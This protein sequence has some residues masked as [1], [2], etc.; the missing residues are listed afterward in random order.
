MKAIFS[1]IGIIIGAWIGE[2]ENDPLTGAAFGFFIGLLSGTLV[3]FNRR[4]FVLEEQLKLVRDNLIGSSTTIKKEQADV[5]SRPVVDT[6]AITEIPETEEVTTEISET[7]TE[8]V[9]STAT[10]TS[11]DS[12]PAATLPPLSDNPVFRFIKRFFTSGNVVVKVAVILLFFGVS[13]LVK[14]AAERN[15]LPIEFRLAAIAAGAIVMLIFGWRLR[16]K[17]ANYALVLQ[18]GAV[19]VLYLTVFA[20]AKL[21][22]V[23]PF[24][25]AFF[26]MLGLVVFS[27][28]LAVMQDAISLA[29]FA[30]AGGF[31]AP[32]LVSTG[33]GN[34][35]ALFSY[36]ALLNLG[37][38]G[39][40]WY[41]SWRALN[42]LG[43]VFTFVIA[44]LWG[45]NYYQPEH[46]RT[47]EP[48]L[49]LFFFF[50]VA[51]AI[52]F[53]HRQ[54][55]QLKGLVDGSL[56]FGTPLIGFTLQSA[57][58]HDFPFGQAYSALG[59]GTIYCLLATALWRR[60]VVGMRMLTEAFLALGVIFLSL[61]IPFALDGRW[62][63]AAWALE[64]AGITWVGIHQRRLLPR[65]FGLLLQLGA[66]I[67]F[68]TTVGHPHGNWPVF[69][70]DYIGSVMIA[71]AG[72]VI[73]WQYFKHRLNVTA[74]EKDLHYL[75]LVWGLLWWFGAGF[76]EID[77][78]VASRY[79]LNA[80]LFFTAASFFALTLLA[81]W[82]DWPAAKYPAVLLLP[83]MVLTGLIQFDEGV[84][85]FARLGYISWI[86]AFA[87][88]YVILHRVEA[89]WKRGL[90]AAWHA[91]SMY[92]FI[93]ILAWIIAHAVSR[94]I[95]GM[96]NWGPI[97]W[98]LIPALVV[99]SLVYL[100]QAFPWPFREYAPSYMGSGLVP[101]ILYLGIWVLA[102]C[103]RKGDPSPLPYIPV[104]NPQDV[105]QLFALLAVIEWVANWK[106]HRM[107]E[108]AF[109]QPHH[110][111]VGVAAVFFVWLNA[112]VA[113]G[114]H[115]YAGVRY[116]IDP[117]FHSDLFQMSISI[118]WTLTAFILMGLATRMAVRKPWF[119]GAALLAAVVLKLFIID[120]DDSGTVTRIISFLTVSGLMLLIGY[121]TPLPP[122]PE[123]QA[124]E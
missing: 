58:V 30:T 32:V 19:G 96:H 64:G 40:A 39:I 33:S 6:E 25:L 106:K 56:V 45:L 13:F 46:F 47:T 105:V 75:L 15:I 99:F 4:L 112:L 120:I 83:A 7:T 111:L 63:A 20:A 116:A 80:S 95:T 8:E 3:N 79:E 84:N 12:A 104:I 66:G 92:I 72:L 100:K 24:T 124:A 49:I 88:Q 28:I 90:K 52:L 36:Y 89:I 68:F 74:P 59:L 16:L 43:F 98:G 14:Y 73:G 110:V 17:N 101:V 42:W 62:T 22:H 27:C 117:M 85:P 115:F 67:A 11:W 53:A 2:W 9:A 21:Y 114:V 61:A 51:I 107:P 26:I 93:F 44:S 23:L 5:T 37:I 82:L 119:T 35:V 41:K 65:L 70:S 1:I 122:K 78:H 48:F 94:H 69:N 121:F 91:G 50:Y 103:F 108:P 86:S 10:D 29:I 34:H 102:V 123:T 71:V 118:V 55:P 54:P 57:L 77:Y 97:F 18:G 87:I 38:F 60:Q 113:H 76:M 31:L 81:G 109:I